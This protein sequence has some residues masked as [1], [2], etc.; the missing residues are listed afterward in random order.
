MELLCAH[1][2]VI[3]AHNGQENMVLKSYRYFSSTSQLPC[4]S[5]ITALDLP[6][7]MCLGAELKHFQNA[8]PPVGIPTKN[9]V[10][11][12]GPLLQERMLAH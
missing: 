8:I 12:L 3:L 4:E 11:T 10:S 2:Y 1:A 9:H 5:G 7:H 6:H